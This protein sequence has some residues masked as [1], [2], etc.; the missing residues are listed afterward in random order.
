MTKKKPTGKPPAV[1]RTKG[2]VPYDMRVRIVREVLRGSGQ[3]DVAMAFG[4]SHAAVQKYM[5]LY[6]RGG[7]DALKPR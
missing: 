7:L 6:R 3:V 2:P 4:I 5:G 1:R